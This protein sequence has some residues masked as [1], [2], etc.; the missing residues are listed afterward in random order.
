M[1]VSNSIIPESQSS[2]KGD[3]SECPY[4]VGHNSLT[5]DFEIILMG[6]QVSHTANLL[7]HLE[8]PSSLSESLWVREM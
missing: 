3:R 7:T 4:T 2:L 8:I 6:V 1:Y 5:S